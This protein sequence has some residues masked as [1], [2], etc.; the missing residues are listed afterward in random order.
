[1]R[2]GAFGLGSHQNFCDSQIEVSI[3]N[4]VKR[5]VQLHLETSF[6]VQVASVSQH[7]EGK[8]HRRSR[9]VLHGSETLFGERMRLLF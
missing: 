5:D 3:L 7:T 6:V 2:L 4:L 8:L 9:V 1:M